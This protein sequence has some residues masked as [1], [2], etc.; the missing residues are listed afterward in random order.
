MPSFFLI[1]IRCSKVVTFRMYRESLLRIPGVFNVFL[2]FSHSRS[3]DFNT[4]T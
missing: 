4:L 3:C 1:R 2:N